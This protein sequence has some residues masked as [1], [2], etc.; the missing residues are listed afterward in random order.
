VLR[1]FLPIPT[2]H[3]I[4]QLTV[5]AQVPTSGIHDTKSKNSKR[6]GSL[7]VWQRHTRMAQ[8]ISTI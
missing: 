2:N 1:A 6:F 8:A 5:I 4:K 7:P 3:A